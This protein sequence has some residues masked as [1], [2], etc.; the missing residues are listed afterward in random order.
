MIFFSFCFALTVM[1]FGLAFLWQKNTANQSRDDINKAFYFHRLEEIQQDEMRGLLEDNQQSTQELQQNLLQDIPDSESSK[2]AE[3]KKDKGAVLGAVFGV[4]ILTLMIYH[5]MGSWQMQANLE[6]VVDQLPYFYQRWE[7]QDKNPLDPNELEQFAFA[8][9]VKLQQSPKAYDWW[10]LGEIAF[11][12]SKF[13]LAKD[14]YAKAFEMEKENPRYILPYARFLMFAD[15]K[16][17]Q[18]K[19]EQMVR[20]VLRNKPDMENT[21]EALSLLAFQYFS[22]KDYKMAAATWAM[23][24]KMVPDDHPKAKILQQSLLVAQEALEEEKGQAEQK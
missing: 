8:L 15:N 13:P 4:F 24:L 6:K 23:M 17:E 20:G 2:L 18:M 12:Q 3:V 7:E 10:Q 11:Q 21:L 1:A 5:Q 9:R 16:V 14:S 22:Q 19:G